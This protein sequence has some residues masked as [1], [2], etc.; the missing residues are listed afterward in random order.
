MRIW[1]F[2]SFYPYDY[3]GMRW[4]GTFAHRQYKGLINNG[5]ELNVILPVLWS[6]PFPFSEMFADW[7]KNRKLNFPEK[8]V[9]D[10]IIIYHPRIA[11]MRPNRFVK[12]SYTERYIDAVANFFKE[13]NIVLDPEHDIFY[14][15]WLLDCVHMLQAARKLGVKCA[16]LG[17]GDDVITWPGSSA[18][19]MEEFKYVVTKADLVLTN[20]DYLGKD[21]QKSSGMQVP[22]VVNY[23]GIDYDK[24]KPVDEAEKLKLRVKYNIPA[25]K[26]VILTVGSP[27]KRKGWLD[28]FDAL[29]EIKKTNTDFLL[30]GGYAGPKD[31]DIPAEVAA[32]GLAEQFYDQG[33]I[34]P[35]LLSEFYNLADIFCLPSHWEGLAT[36]VSEGMASGLPVVTTDVCGQPEIVKHNETGILVSAKDKVGLA[37]ELLSLIE[38]KEMRQELGAAAR[39]FIVDTW[40]NDDEN[41]RKLLGILKSIL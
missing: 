36:V 21:I 6:P 5:A 22:Y 31:L 41:S 23:F 27:L 13:N 34:K 20:A 24:F 3:P 29:A 26:I 19:E 18:K 8:R 40:G 9:Y 30:V 4:A 7:K 33:E 35:E 15:Q 25:N 28:L 14:G 17:I 1:A 37:N 10:G 12:K 11:N 38:N 32:R 2:P 16:V 39:R